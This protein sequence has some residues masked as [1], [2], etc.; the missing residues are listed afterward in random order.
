V[1]LELDLSAKQQGQ[2]KVSAEQTAKTRT[3]NERNES[4]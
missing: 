1:T 3:W 4:K 2:M